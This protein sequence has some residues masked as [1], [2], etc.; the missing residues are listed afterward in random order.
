VTDVAVNHLV[1]IDTTTGQLVKELFSGNG[2]PGM[3]DLVSTG[4]FIYALSPGNGTVKAAV[5]V[6]DVS[7]G[8][9]SK[10]C[11]RWRIKRG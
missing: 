8:K 4:N 3:I 10:F 9:G 5:A 2:N 11:I 1:E 7:G 6:F